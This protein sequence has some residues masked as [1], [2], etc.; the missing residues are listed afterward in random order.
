MENLIGYAGI[1]TTISLLLLINR[2]I[3][4][5]VWYNFFP[6]LIIWRAMSILWIPHERT[7]IIVVSSILWWIWTKLTTKYINLSLYPKY[8]LYLLMSLSIFISIGSWYMSYNHWELLPIELSHKIMLFFLIVVS[9]SIKTYIWWKGVNS[10]RRRVHI[11]WFFCISYMINILLEQKHLYDYFSQHGL[12]IILIGIVTLLIWSYTW[13]QLKEMI[14][15]R[16]LIWQKIT[17]KKKRT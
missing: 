8:S 6:P 5:W 2:H 4:W 1:L 15:F 13:L 11:I 7:L 10:L 17:N 9:T 3:I 14:R 16:K 12:I